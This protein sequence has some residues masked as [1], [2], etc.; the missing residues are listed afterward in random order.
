MVA[1]VLLTGLLDYPVAADTPAAPQQTVPWPAIH[2]E[3]VTE[4]SQPIQA[5][6]AGDGSGR[7]FVVEKRGVVRIFAGGQ[8]LATPFLDIDARVD[9][10]C[11]ECGLLS[12]AFPPDF[13]DS[14]VFYVYYNSAEDLLDPE[15]EPNEGPDSVIAR[16]RLTDNDNVADPESEVQ[17]L[18]VNQPYTN[19]NGG[20]IKFGPDGYLYIALGDGGRGGDP[21]NS[22]Q[23]TNTL[24]GKLL[25]IE[26]EATGPS[27]TIPADNPFATSTSQRREIWAYGLRNP[28]QYSFD[29]AT[30]DLYLGDVGQGRYE[31][32]NVAPAANTQAH[33]YGWNIMEGLHCYR[34][35][36]CNQDG[37]TLPVHEYAQDQPAPEED[38]C[39]VTGGV[40]YRGAASSLRSIYLFADYCSGRIWGMQRDN[41]R[42]PVH[43]FLN[44]DHAIVSFGE[45][46]AGEVYV[47]DLSGGIYRIVVDQILRNSIFLPVVSQ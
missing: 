4:A 37:L 18:V 38:N 40:V 34:A 42:W 47:V 29:R 32:I 5:T 27:Y 3:E 10:T 7:L 25:R 30:G 33:N 41:N 15:D 11:G 28:W 20:L 2:L 21:L 45:D 24:L 9:S 16:F 19:H 23:R 13:E 35:E 22:G 44:T 6:H 8:L 43:E 1:T 14:R 26:V 17:I 31:E 46:E 36:E 39:S 12:I